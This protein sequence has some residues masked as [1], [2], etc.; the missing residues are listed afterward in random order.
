MAKNY[1]GMLLWWIW[2]DMNNLLHGQK[3]LEPL[4]LV[5]KGVVGILSSSELQGKAA[6]MNGK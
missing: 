4:E 6:K 5:R 1:F 2:K 3:S